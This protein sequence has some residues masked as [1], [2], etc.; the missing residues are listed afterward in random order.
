MLRSMS[1]NP[2]EWETD[3]FKFFYASRPRCK[4]AVREE[5]QNLYFLSNKHNDMMLQM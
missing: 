1:P 2:T 3:L 5:L 4:L